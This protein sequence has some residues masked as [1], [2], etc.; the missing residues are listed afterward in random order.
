MGNQDRS[1]QVWPARSVD[2]ALLV[3]LAI[4]AIGA[5]ALGLQ[6]ARLELAA[7]G[8]LGVF[9]LA[10]AM[11]WYKAGSVATRLVLAAAIAAQVSIQIHLAQDAPQ[12]HFNVFVCLSVLVIY[13]DWRPLALAGVVFVAYHV[14]LDR[15]LAA[16]FGTGAPVNVDPS[17]VTLHVLFVTVQ[18]LA[19]TQIARV[20]RRESDGLRELDILVNAMGRDGPIRL[21]L[22]SIRAVTPTGIRLRH[23]Q[24][25]MAAALA[26]VAAAV[27]TVRESAA[28]VASGGAEL[29][30]RTDTTARE[31]NESAMSLAQI[32]IIV[33]H[34]ND[35]ASQAREMSD[36]AAGMADQGDQLVSSV[37]S[38]MQRIGEASRK[39]TDIIGVI[40]GIA[41]QTNILALNAAVEAAR[42]GDQGRGFAVVAG[43][44]RSL[45]QRSAAAAREVRTLIQSSAS[46]VDE[47]T[48]LVDGAGRTMNAL[49]ESVRRV[50]DLFQTINND[51]NEHVQGLEMVTGS[52]TALSAS[53]GQNVAVAQRADEAAGNLARQVE[54]LE[55]VLRAFRLGAVLAGAPTGTTG[56]EATRQAAA[57]LPSPASAPAASTAAPAPPPGVVPARPARPSKTSAV[58]FF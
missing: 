44:V 25:R 38:T 7:G 42:A 1:R 10:A 5:I 8:S 22:S 17:H 48:R 27:A 47:G 30:E 14:G 53:T 43:E 20:L 19:L 4:N 24:E 3:V 41:F 56:D 18:V 45:A 33:S 9:A 39:I 40:D 16:A 52:M 6:H 15:L 50:G 57:A 23:V 58:E 28:T 32:G 29:R 26:E 37:V 35:A 11:V 21:D 12:Y 51:A 34:S 31:L 13:R 46:T 54:R 2:R 55:D 36:S 49:V